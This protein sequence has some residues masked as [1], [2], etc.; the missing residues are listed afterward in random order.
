MSITNEEK[1]FM[2]ESI[3]N[4]FLIKQAETINKD[5]NDIIVNYYLSKMVLL[6]KN[7][8]VA[9]LFTDG[10]DDDL[11]AEYTLKNNMII[12]FNDLDIFV[13]RYKYYNS[14]KIDTAFYLKA[15]KDKDLLSGR[16]CLVKN[17]YLIP[18]DM[19]T[20]EKNILRKSLPREYDS[21]IVFDQDEYNPDYYKNKNEA[22]MLNILSKVVAS[23]A[24]YSELTSSAFE[25]IFGE[26]C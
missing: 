25:T 12:E 18:D 24:I 23:S 14:W 8:F 1:E 3:S 2:E 21:M 11:K 19:D 17:K 20:Y 22:E 7:A 16:V 10:F 9:T 13:D 26:P 5:Y 6:F 4:E 15:D